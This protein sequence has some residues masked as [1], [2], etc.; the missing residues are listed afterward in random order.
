MGLHEILAEA[1]FEQQSVTKMRVVDHIMDSIY[2]L[3]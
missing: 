1:V 3:D 2:L